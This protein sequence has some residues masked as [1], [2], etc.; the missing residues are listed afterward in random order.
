MPSASTLLA[1]HLRSGAGEY[2]FDHSWAHAAMY[3]GQRYYPK[4]QC[5]VP[6][7]PV[8]GPRLLVHPDANVDAMREAMGKIIASVAGACPHAFQP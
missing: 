5:C 3:T 2:V 1:A 6:F 8:T 7:S 4:L